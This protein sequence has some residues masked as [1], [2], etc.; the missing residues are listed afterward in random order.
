MV[1]NNTVACSGTGCVARG[2]GFSNAWGATTLTRS[3]ISGNRVTGA[4]A[5]GGGIFNAGSVTLDGGAVTGNT[6]NNCRPMGS[7]GGCTN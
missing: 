1:S 2:G 7:I 4:T 6:P 3:G 5:E